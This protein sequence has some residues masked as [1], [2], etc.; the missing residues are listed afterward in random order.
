MSSVHSEGGQ[1][2]LAWLG[3]RELA[4]LTLVA[5]VCGGLWGFIELADEVAEG[6]TQSLD[7]HVLLLMR[8]PQDLSD[9]LGPPWLE[10]IMRDFTALGGNAVLTGLSLAVAGF[11]ILAG[12]P[13]TVWFLVIAIGGA[14]LASTLLKMGFDRPRPDLV[15]H[16][17]VV[18]TRSF[19]SGHSML[20]AATYLSL[21]A[22]L[23]RVVRL[24]RLKAYLICLALTCTLLIGISRVYLGVHWPSD[25]LAGWTLGAVWALLCWLGMRA[26][27]RR[28]VVEPEAM[29]A[30]EGG[31]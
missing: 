13:H 3:R 8:E 27:Q 25:V 14:L 2:F 17:S 20:A 1:G 26:L 28:R 4:T 15:P 9:P 23:M 7:R 21:A 30:V 10:E 31:D 19:P 16:G 24:R 12:R 22:L 29:T 6:E 11:L 5:I 18:Y